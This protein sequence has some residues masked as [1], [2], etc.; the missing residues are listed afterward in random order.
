M[1][2]NLDQEDTISKLANIVGCTI[3]SWLVK[4]LGLP[5]GGNPLQYTFWEPILP[6]VVRRLEGWKRAFMSKGDQLTRTYSVLASLPINNLS[7]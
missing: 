7:V 6:R 1:E 5:L 3:G 2:V 4:Y